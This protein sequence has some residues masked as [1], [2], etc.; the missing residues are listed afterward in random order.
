MAWGFAKATVVFVVLSFL[1]YWL[2]G[3]TKFFYLSPI[4]LL[5][6]GLQLYAGRYIPISNRHDSLVSKYGDVYVKEV[7]WAANEHG[8]RKLI[9][10][11]WFESYAD[12]FCKRR[13]DS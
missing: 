11:R 2:N 9:K 8:I 4:F 6:G 13:A 7:T 1:M 5:I 3:S 10:T 12:D